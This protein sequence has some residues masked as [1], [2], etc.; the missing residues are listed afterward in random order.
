M[1]N[2]LPQADPS[3]NC[4]DCP[5]RLDP[6]GN[7]GNLC[8]SC[9]QTLQSFCC[10][11][12]AISCE[13]KFD[14]NDTSN[15]DFLELELGT[16]TDGFGILYSP[17]GPNYDIIAYAQ[18][19]ANAV[20]TLPGSTFFGTWHSVCMEF[21]RTDDNTGILSL[22]AD[23]LQASGT[24]DITTGHIK[25]DT[26]YAGARQGTGNAHRTIRCVKT[27][28]NLASDEPVF[29]FPSPDSFDSFTTGASIVN[30]NL[31][32]D[33]TGADAY[34]QK[35]L[36]EPYNMTRSEV[37]VT[38]TSTISGTCTSG[39]AI[40]S[41]AGQAFSGIVS[42]TTDS[43]PVGA[44]AEIC[45]GSFTSTQGR[46]HEA[47]GATTTDV[48][49]AQSYALG[50]VKNA[51][52]I[53]GTSFNVGDWVLFVGSVGAGPLGGC[54]PCSSS[55]PYVL[56]LPEVANTLVLTVGGITQ[57]INLTFNL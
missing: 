29:Q 34:G 8:G 15:Q 13:V 57:T 24:F 2:Y 3:G 45:E 19:G 26:V 43:I 11:S 5:E 44:T 16:G 18:V 21:C 46:L 17:N 31:R 50:V 40:T 56:V 35:T 12:H 30:G 32:I 39:I 53:S 10:C 48:N 4:C 49:F 33:S 47:C 7:C 27:V 22:I 37:N 14:S 25:P 41:T 38:L 20:V 36:S 55:Y 9:S 6:C 23:G 1:A 51:G 42:V 54:G 52:T 28:G